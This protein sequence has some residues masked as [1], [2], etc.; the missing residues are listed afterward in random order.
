MVAKEVI[1]IARKQIGL[2]FNSVIKD[3]SLTIQE[4][5]NQSGLSKNVISSI[6]NGSNYS[7]SSFVTLAAFLDTHIELSEKSIEKSIINTMGPKIQNN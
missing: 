3:K 2:Y 6:L 4:V 5:S 7:I 1:E